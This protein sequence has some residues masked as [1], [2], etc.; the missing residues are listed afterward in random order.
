[1]PIKKNDL[2][3]L[4]WHPNK[5]LKKNPIYYASPKAIPNTINT[6]YIKTLKITLTNAPIPAAFAVLGF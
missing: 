4:P 6:T 1:M 3:A 2:S 5:I